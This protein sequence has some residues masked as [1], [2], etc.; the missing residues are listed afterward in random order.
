MVATPN[1][2]SQQHMSFFAKTINGNRYFIHTTGIFW[3]EEDI[4]KDASCTSDGHAVHIMCDKIRK[5]WDMVPLRK[6]VH[7]CLLGG[8]KEGGNATSPLRSQGPQTRGQSKV[9]MYARGNN[10][11]PSISK[12]RPLLRPGAQIVA[13]RLHRA[14]Y[15]PLAYA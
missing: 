7:P 3:I 12:Y 11:A 15:A 10:D 14:K 6:S 9:K 8:P 13:L 4:T 5:V 2:H 1:V